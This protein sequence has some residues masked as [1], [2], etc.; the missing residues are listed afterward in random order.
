MQVT[1][2]S[3]VQ[4]GEPTLESSLSLF[5]E[6]KERNIAYIA[7]Q[8]TDLFGTCKQLLVHENEWETLME[9]RI[10]I[11]GSSVEGFGSVHESDLVLRPDPATLHVQQWR[12]EEEGGP[13][14]AMFSDV[15]NLD[16]SLAQGCTRSMLKQV[17]AEASRLGY[18]CQIGLEGE[19]FLFPLEEGKPVL[20]EH[21]AGG[22]CDVF[23]LDLGE[24][25]RMDIVSALQEQG[26]AMEA[27]HHEVAPGQHEI[28]FRFGDALQVADQ[29]QKFKQ[30]VKVTAGRNGMHAS[31]IP[32]P[33]SGRNGNAL[34]CNQSLQNAAG[35]NVFCD[36]RTSTGL[37]ETAIAYIGGL[38]RHTDAIA[39]IANP[40]V[41]SYKRLIRGYEAP[42][43]I[44]WSRSNRTASVRIPGARGKQTRIEMR[45]PDPTANPYLLFAVM[46]KAGLDGIVSSMKPAA[47]AQGN[48]YDM[49]PDERRQCQIR[50][51][52]R[53]LHDA[54]EHMSDSEL[55]REVMGDQAFEQYLAVKSQEADSFAAEVHPWE[56]EAYMAKY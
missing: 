36:A 30:I 25:T 4:T 44:A 29:W 39:A 5:R 16:G 43:H 47:E 13:V 48:I 18:N 24:K 53:D 42:T 21:D 41:N 11:D 54:L 52:P 45:T 49:T 40:T 26:F 12:T 35:D 33:F 23:P 15:G 50:H 1:M 8:F 3:S 31:F 9:G 7:V 17:L 38:L 19:F 55:V 46:L 6:L 28:N 14:A 27:A 37:S 56:I 2:P 22:Y 34:H 32:K 51:Y 20:R 10:M